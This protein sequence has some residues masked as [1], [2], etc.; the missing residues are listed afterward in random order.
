MGGPDGNED[1]YQLFKE[2][3]FVA[4]AI[5]QVYSDIYDMIVKETARFPVL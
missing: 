2:R 3:C 4:N 1:K 5:A